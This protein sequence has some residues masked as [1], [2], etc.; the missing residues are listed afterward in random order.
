MTLKC[1]HCDH[2]TDLLSE[3]GARVA[4]WRIFRGRSLTGAPL[5]DVLCPSCSGRAVPKMLAA[6]LPQ[7]S[8]LDLLA[9]T[10]E[11]Q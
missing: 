5:S 9:T 1:V 7:D 11:E 10:E 3:D 2:S 8:L 4:G 6:N